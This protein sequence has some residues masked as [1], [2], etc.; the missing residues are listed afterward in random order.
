MFGLTGC[1]S[2][3]TVE[4]D[5]TEDINIQTN[6]VQKD[7]DESNTTKVE[8]NKEQTKVS[9]TEKEKVKNSDK[10]ENLTKQEINEIEGFI[11]NIN[12]L[13]TG[14]L[15]IN[16]DNPEDLTKQLSEYNI[17][18]LRYAI[19]SSGYGRKAKTGTDW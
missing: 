19:I 6:I 8:S 10:S 11:N 5:G 7:K 9:E 3:I 15:F 14:F 13:N 4:T 12:E 1:T 2:K 17:L 16:Y 18:N